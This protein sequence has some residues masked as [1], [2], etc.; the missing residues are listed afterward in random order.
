MKTAYDFSKQ[1]WLGNTV[2]RLPKHDLVFGTP[3]NDPVGGIPLG[4]GDMGSLL[5]T[6]EDTLHINVNKCDLWDDSVQGDEVFCSSEEENLTCLR[7]GG[8]ITVKVNTPCFEILYLD[9]FEARLSLSDAT[10][11]VFSSTPFGKFNM[12]SFA[13][14]GAHATVTDFSLEF[15]EEDAP[16]ITLARFG[17][18][19]MWRWYERFKHD[20]HAGLSGTTPYVEKNG[21]YITQVLNG[22]V[23]CIGLI[24][25]TNE[26]YTL[27]V[28]NGHSCRLRL[29][30]GKTHRFTLYHTIALGEDEEQAKLLCMKTLNVAS[31]T[32]YGPMK[33][34]H[35][36]AWAS[37][38]NR[39]FIKIPDNYVENIYYYSLYISNSECR[40]QYPPHFTQGLWGFRH[41]FIP[42]NYYFHY[43]MQHMYGPLNS[44]GHWE[45]AENYYRMRRAG[46]QNACRYAREVK[47]K[48][49]AFYHDVTD[50]YG[51]GANYDSENCTPGPQLAMAMWRHYRYTG[52]EEFLKET[53]LPVMCETAE[54]YLSMLK[55]G[56]DG[57]YHLYDT[58]AYEGNLPCNDCL[59]DMAMIRVLFDKLC[60]L[61]E[62]KE[63]ERY[64]D[65]L[66]NLPDFVTVQLEADEFDGEVLLFGIGEGQK[67]KGE[68][69]VLSYG[70]EDDGRPVR[71]TYGEPSR[72]KAIYGFPDVEFALLY[73]SGLTGLAQRGTPVFEAL[74]NQMLLHPSDADCMSWCMAPIYLARMGMAD[75]IPDYLRKVLDRWQT[76][77]NGFNGDGPEGCV[78]S[79]QRFYYRT[80]YDIETKKKS[81][82]DIYYFRYFDFETIPIIATGASEALFQSYDGV[83]RICP[84]V[85][86]QD[87][88]AFRLYAEGG[89][90]VQAEVSAESYIITV[91]SLRSEPCLVKLPDYADIG[92]LHIYKVAEGTMMPVDPIW[93]E[94]GCERVL[95]FTGILDCG[96]RLVLCSGEYSE[97][98]TKVPEVALPNM[99]MKECGR[100]VLGSPRLPFRANP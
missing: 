62:G 4:D 100:A 9:D 35:N 71:R 56:E 34:E 37:F 60:Q 43:N 3:V 13:S 16:E 49:G 65:V 47:G 40:G 74:Y 21:M 36:A 90:V 38:W 87:S 66:D 64:Q 28:V 6:S 27:E 42:W 19:N 91:D 5:W 44:A 10:A 98:E 22:T 78:Q 39:S 58:T 86:P 41:D 72:R 32:G 46:L 50:R 26:K 63:K 57:L 85:R 88:V 23:F 70:W 76:F 81:N 99:D 82:L 33:E 2:D 75:V 30:K 83:L 12:T 55:K 11:R 84:A 96:E 54:F 1:E 45:L 53:A 77:P 31:A 73:P 92:V 17:S 61:T 8:E 79:R 59:T 7:H 51:R 94:N 67:P 80:P 89:F 52:D 25:C 95:D 68:K 69:K 15:T 18:R 29:E 97:W 48:A 14:A 24:I 20:V 93:R